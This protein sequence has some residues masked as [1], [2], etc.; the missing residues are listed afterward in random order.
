MPFSRMIEESVPDWL[1]RRFL[2]Q[3]LGGGGEDVGSSVEVVSYLVKSALTP[4][5]NFAS[6]LFRVLLYYKSDDSSEAVKQSLIVKQPVKAGLIYEIASKTQFYDKETVFYGGLLEKMSEKVNCKLG[7]KSF[8]S[9]VEQVVV[10]EDLKPEYIVA[11]KNLQLDLQH[12]ELVFKFLAKYHA[13]AVAV[14]HD[15]PKL[16]ES[17]SGECEFTIDGPIRRWAE[18]G[19]KFIG[20]I[21]KEMG[22]RDLGDFVLSRADGIWESAVETLK[23]RP[24]HFNVLVH[25]DIWTTNLMFKYNSDKELV[26]MKVLDFQLARYTTPVVDLLYYLYTS[27]NDTV[28]DHHQVELFELYVKELN[29][30]LQQLGCKERF[31]MKELIG[32][33]NHVIPWFIA[34]FVYGMIPIFV[35][36]TKDGL[37]M[38][39]ITGKDIT[40]GKCNPILAKMFSCKVIRALLPNLMRQYVSMLKGF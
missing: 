30:N 36:G 3:A 37:D 8:Y 31:S 21:L 35:H 9:P 32:D 13:S 2:E 4:G 22:F 27:A 10:L 25:G 20:D 6:Y 7:P 1:D 16:I 14:N 15:D 28:R 26:D 5:E 33:I 11:D 39:G 40:S 34:A 23:A 38:E 19:T 29:K 18:F 17:V 24:G 12:S